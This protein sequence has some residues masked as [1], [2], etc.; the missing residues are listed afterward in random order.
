MSI[1]RDS[2]VRDARHDEIPAIAEVLDAAYAEFSPTGDA[3]PEFRAEFSRYREHIRDVAHRFDLSSQ[4]V[5][6]RDGKL[7]ASVTYCAPGGW[8]D[9]DFRWD[10][11]SWAAIRLLGVHPSARGLGLGKLLA[12]ECVRRARDDGATAVALHSTPP[13]VI[14]RAMYERMGFERVPQ[15]DVP[16]TPDFVVVAY[17]LR[18]P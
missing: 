18:F 8:Y 13:M 1:T 11:P 14:A 6:E 12:Q 4:I 15:Y 2:A 17:L 10:E 3:D 5:A 9:D 7:A 16:I